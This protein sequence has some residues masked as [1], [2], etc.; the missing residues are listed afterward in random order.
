M[1]SKEIFYKTQ[2]RTI[3]KNLEKRQM[4][5]FYFDNVKDAVEKALSFIPKNGVAGHGG[6]MTLEESGLMDA[7][8]KQQ[9]F[10]FLD[11]S[12]ASSQNEVAEIYH[13]ALS[14][15]TF[16]LSTNA[17]TLNGEL[18]NID[19]TGNRLAALIY[20]PDTVVVLAG[21]NKVT[22]EVPSALERVHNQATPQNCIRLDKKTPC[23]TTGKCG[24]CLSPDCICNQ[25][26]VTRRSGIP[27]RIK[28]ILVGEC[29]GY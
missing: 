24:D 27:G 16:F 10:C 3:I 15:N 13:K 18:V 20:G 8:K 23:S 26:V 19:G 11:R 21:M 4:E 2:A 25:V 17:I 12:K 6:S 22:V 1:N 7:L 9:G 29:L 5:G 14:A 28:V